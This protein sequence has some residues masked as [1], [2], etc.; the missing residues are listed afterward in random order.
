VSWANE[1][2]EEMILECWHEGIG[3]EESTCESAIMQVVSEGV[4]EWQAREA[5]RR[6]EGEPP[7]ISRVD[8]PDDEAAQAVAVR[9]SASRWFSGDA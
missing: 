9:S 4:P 3:L 1:Q 6:L 8:A 5:S 2:V 7:R